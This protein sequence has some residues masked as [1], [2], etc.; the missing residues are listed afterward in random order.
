[1]NEIPI[2]LLLS[3]IS[4]LLVLSAFFSSAE[5]G[6]M[7]LNK[8]RLKHLIKQNNRS[9]KRAE[10]L[11]Q[12]PD[13]LLGVILI[14]NNFVNI[15]AAALTT[16]LCLELFGNSGVFIG[17]VVLTIIILI[18]AEVTPKTFAAKNAENIALPASGILKILQKILY[19]LI[20]IVNFFSNNLLNLLNVK[21]TDSNEDITTEELKSVLENSG[22][23]IPKRYQ[24]M[25]ISILDLDEILIDEIMTPRNEIVGIDLD[26]SFEKLMQTV[27][28][29]S[30]EIVPVYEQ[31]LDNLKGVISFNGIKGF[32][33]KQGNSFDD[34]MEFV[35]D[36][37]VALEN[38]SL[39]NQLFNFQKDNKTSAVV[40]DEY[41]N[42]K[43]IVSINDILEEIVGELSSN[44][45][46]EKIDF[47]KQK[48]G[49]FLIDGSVS[50]REI[51]K[52]LSWDLPL[53]G[54]VTLNG[55]ILEKIE[56][57]PESNIS[58]N[59]NN[60]IIET[61]LIKDNMIKF[62][63]VSKISIGENEG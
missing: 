48:D 22:D 19:P 25:L 52:K 30:E 51:N 34:F 61:V 36:V 29:N 6:M 62:A 3:S 55:L 4:I 12:R 23:L 20:W 18:F 49:S 28:E 35:N 7:A 8:Y 42:V 43:G 9:A 32:L 44:Q 58:I 53:E 14:G 59:L 13:R 31:N 40:V 10:K 15:L 63:K 1:M 45:T 26:D 60:Y 27:S 41:G 39:S 54:P 2:W 17:S 38:T 57:I 56:T 46:R 16:I 47:Q 11:L 33:L 5:T 37:Y 24:D 21:E 50:I